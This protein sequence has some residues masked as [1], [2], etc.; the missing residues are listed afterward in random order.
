MSLIL[1]LPLIAGSM[2]LVMAVLTVF[3]VALT[4]RSSG[5]VVYSSLHGIARLWRK[6]AT[7]QQRCASDA[8][9]WNGSA[10][11]SSPSPNS[12]P[13]RGGEKASD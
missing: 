3:I 8:I 2:L 4:L 1:A 5:T 13:T 9:A 10:Y 7:H 11:L 6:A 12:P